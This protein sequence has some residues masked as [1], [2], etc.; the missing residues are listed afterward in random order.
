MMFA[1]MLN[2]KARKNGTKIIE[3]LNIHE[4]SIIADIGSG[5]GYFVYEFSQIVGE[6][7]IVYAVDTN[8][9]MLQYVSSNIKKMNLNNIKTVFAEKEH[10]LF[11][12]N[13]C[14]LIFMCNVFHHIEN[15]VDYFINLKNYLKKDGRIAIIDYDK[16][17]KFSYIALTGH[18]TEEK[19]ILDTMKSA[20]FIHLD[21]IKILEK[22]SF[23]IFG[24]NL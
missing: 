3:K 10:D 1:N 15:P 19:T 5:G 18:T 7:G 12:K 20:G 14:D 8:E 11:P 21:N 2:K 13:S 22:Q 4:G 23:N 16:R 6:K 17:N 9:K 24:N